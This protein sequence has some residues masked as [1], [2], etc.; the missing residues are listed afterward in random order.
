VANVSTARKLSILGR[1]VAQQ[2]GQSRT[3]GALLQA[4][5]AFVSH[6]SRVLHQLWLEVTGFIFLGIALI[7]GFGLHHEYLEYQAGRV[8]PGRAWL[9]GGVTVMFIWFGLSSFWKSRR[10]K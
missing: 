1:M 7:C 3:G 4:G 9:A 8:G 2:A 5:K 6:A 10:K